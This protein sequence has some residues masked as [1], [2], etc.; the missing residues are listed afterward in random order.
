MTKPEPAEAAV[1]R[2][3]APGLRQYRLEP[4]LA[5]ATWTPSVK[6][7]E[8]APPQAGPLLSTTIPVTARTLPEADGAP[9]SAVL[10]V[11]EPS[12]EV[13]VPMRPIAGLRPRPRV[14]I[15]ALEFAP[16]VHVDPASCLKFEDFR[17]A[18]MVFGAPRLPVLPA[19]MKF[20][21]PSRV[22]P[23]TIVTKTQPVNEP[24]REQEVPK[25][26]KPG[27]KLPTIPAARRSSGPVIPSIAQPPAV[28][29]AQ[30]SKSFWGAFRKYIKK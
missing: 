29:A 28:P 20:E 30:P 13:G 8:P 5:G 14:E 1:P 16:E 2:P 12:F 23:I 15:D 10:P 19:G 11:V 21:P 3:Q 18:V 22:T 27:P 7:E 9:V 6:V 17:F 4:E 26:E 24:V 25:P